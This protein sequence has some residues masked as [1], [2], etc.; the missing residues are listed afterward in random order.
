ME[1]EK[2]LTPL[3]DLTTQIQDPQIKAIFIELFNIIEE[4][5]SENRTLKKENQQLRDEVNRLK[6]ENGKPDIKPN[7]RHSENISSEKE[8]NKKKGWKKSAKKSR[9]P[10][11]NRVHC[12][13]D[14]NLCLLGYC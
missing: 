14:K 4:L 7:R 10:I 5:A 8:R 11:D 1:L 12:P 3:F 6:G 2:R 13:I 9:I